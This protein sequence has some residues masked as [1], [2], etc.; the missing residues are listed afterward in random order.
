[1]TFY[2]NYSKQFDVLI[3]TLNN[4]H[5]VTNTKAD[6][7]VTVLYH[8]DEIVGFNLFH[9]G[10]TKSGWLSF[11]DEAVAVATKKVAKYMP[12]TQGPQFVVAEITEC[13]DIA[14]THL[15]QCAVNV[16]TKILQIVCGAENARVGLKTVCAVEGA[17]LPNGMLITAG[18][19]KGIDSFGMLCSGRE[20]N[21]TQFG[22]KGIIELDAHYP[23]GANFF[24]VLK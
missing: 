4:N 5:D 12:L 19:L 3:V 21:L 13:T 17:F 18:K 8:N 7:D 1:M 15:H 20:L 23:V 9:P 11:D 14:G 16:G 2:L 10:L 24:E 22:A 6:G